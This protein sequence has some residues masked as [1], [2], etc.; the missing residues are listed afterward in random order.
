M[1]IS[2]NA[3]KDNQPNANNQIKMTKIIATMYKKTAIKFMF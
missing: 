1:K 3:N 2:R